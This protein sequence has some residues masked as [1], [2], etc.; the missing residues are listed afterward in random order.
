MEAGVDDIHD[1]YG[2][3]PTFSIKHLPTPR[4]RFRSIIY[5][6]CCLLRLI[7]NRPDAAIGRYVYTCIASVKLGIPTIFDSHAPIWQDG[8]ISTLLFEQLI[9]SKHLKQI[10]T[11]SIA[12]KHLYLKRYP[13]LAGKITALHNGAGAPVLKPL[14]T[15]WPGRKDTLQVG[16]VGSLYAGRGV[17]VITNCAQELAHFDFHIVGGDQAEIEKLESKLECNNLFFHGHK[18]H[19]ETASYREHCDIL[20]AP[21]QRNVFNKAGTQDSTTFMCPIKVIE[22]LSSAKAI[23]A[24]DL[25]TIRELLTEDRAVLVTPDNLTEWQGAIE[26][27]ADS[28]TLRAKLSQNAYSHYLK[29]LTWKARAK[30]TLELLT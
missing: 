17:E 18:A 19:H 1:Y 10:T 25:P 22:Y 7:F 21:Y 27:L 4:I 15:I 8:K 26:Q 3:D 28:K 20:L 24:S 29:N 6:L 9:K 11:N 13:E 30:G 23:I 5:S 14:K 2:V 16:Y 12:L